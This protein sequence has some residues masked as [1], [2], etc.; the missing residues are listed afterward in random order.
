VK[1]TAVEAEVE[2]LVD[3][4]RRRLHDNLARNHKDAVLE[5]FL[6]LDHKIGTTIE[7]QICATE[8]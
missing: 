8:R 7:F 5:S 6:N 1:V 3:S 4:D 2:Q